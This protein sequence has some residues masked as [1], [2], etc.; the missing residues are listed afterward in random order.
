MTA[1]ATMRTPTESRAATSQKQQQGLEFPSPC[2]CSWRQGDRRDS[3][4]R[5][6]GPQPG[7]LPTELRPPYRTG[8]LDRR[9]IVSILAMD[10]PWPLAQDISGAA[11]TYPR[12]RSATSSAR[13]DLPRMRSCLRG[14]G[15]R[16]VHCQG[17]LPIQWRLTPGSGRCR[18]ETAGREV[19]CNVA[20]R[21][22]RK[23]G[24]AGNRAC[25]ATKPPGKDVEL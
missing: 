15:P 11:S 18:S 2:C 24:F 22:E 7:A 16:S 8:I 14:G 1:I 6:P 19:I 12:E 17:W 20:V 25:S 21:P 13:A 9:R 4:P 10:R 5:R 23:N 3:N